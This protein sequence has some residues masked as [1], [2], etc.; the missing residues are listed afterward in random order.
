MLTAVRDLA[1]AQVDDALLRVYELL[2]AQPCP[3][4]GGS[5]PCPCDVREAAVYKPH[6]CATMKATSK[7][8]PELAGS[9]AAEPVR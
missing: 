1:V 7:T 6:T 5:F 8:A 4:C 2:L 3:D 9:D